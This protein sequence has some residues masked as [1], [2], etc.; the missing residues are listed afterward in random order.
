MLRVTTIRNGS[1]VI[2]RLEGRLLAPW[3]DEF[4]SACARADAGSELMALDLADLTYVDEAGA[5]LLRRLVD[6]GVPICAC[7]AFVAELLREQQTQL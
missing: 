1:Q 2:L 7:S 4:R 5:R 6:Q 3:L